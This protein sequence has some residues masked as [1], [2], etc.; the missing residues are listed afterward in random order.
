LDLDGDFRRRLSIRV[1][2]EEVKIGLDLRIGCRLDV[3]GCHLL[4]VLAEIG[5]LAL[6]VLLL[7]FFLLTLD[8]DLNLRNGIP[9]PVASP[10]FHVATSLPACP[11]TSSRITPQQTH[12]ISVSI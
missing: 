5:Q 6:H 9:L 12:D 4:L 1:L 2:E 3:I 7:Q 10:P 11:H 8:I